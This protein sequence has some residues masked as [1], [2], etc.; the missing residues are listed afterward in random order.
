MSELNP[1]SNQ[2]TEFDQKFKT[3]LGI[4]NVLIISSFVFW[5]AV[6]SVLQSCGS[7]VYPNR[8]PSLDKGE[9]TSLQCL[10]MSQPKHPV[11]KGHAMSR[12]RMVSLR[13]TAKR[14]Q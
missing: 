7:P 14:H 6:I 5:L 1:T 3:P 10:K 2:D 11:S 8:H 12:Q 13:L 4:N 9:Y